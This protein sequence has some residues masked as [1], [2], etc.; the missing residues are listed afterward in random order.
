MMGRLDGVGS[1][2]LQCFGG[3]AGSLSCRKG[4]GL[5][6]GK[7]ISGGFYLKVISVIPDLYSPT[8]NAP[9]EGW[10][11]LQKLV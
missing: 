11:F 9:A 6:V 3:C 8:A 1:E 4:I 7:S 2:L 10:L 5:G